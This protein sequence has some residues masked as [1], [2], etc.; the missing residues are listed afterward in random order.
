MNIFGWKKWELV[1]EDVPQIRERYASPVL[2]SFLI[3]S[4]RV[5]VDI[6][7]REN[8]RTGKVKYKKVIKN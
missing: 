3:S 1:E 5:L 2:G 8:K 7:K 4:N 6:Y